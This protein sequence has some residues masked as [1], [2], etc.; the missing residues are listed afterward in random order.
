M[1]PKGW[2]DEEQATHRMRQGTDRLGHFAG[3]PESSGIH[4]GVPAK[5]LAIKTAGFLQIAGPRFCVDLHACMCPGATEKTRHLG[6][7]PVQPCI[8]SLWTSIAVKQDIGTRIPAPE[9][10]RHGHPHR[11]YRFSGTATF[12]ARVA[13]HFAHV[14]CQIVLA[15][16]QAARNSALWGNIRKGPV[17][18]GI[19]AFHG[20]LGDPQ[21]RNLAS[22]PADSVGVWGDMS[23]IRFFPRIPIPEQE[24]CL[25]QGIA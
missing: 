20:H 11:R 10:L 8:Q 17:Q 6:E 22:A 25:G 3:Q 4:L 18:Q 5:S 13:V 15:R 7:Q 16:N 24:Y 9:I 14:C 21:P 2:P 19:T 12:P 23:G 1:M